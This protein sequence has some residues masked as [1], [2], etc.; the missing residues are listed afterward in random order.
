MATTT[1]KT[2]KLDKAT[3]ANGL[4]SA[5][6][7]ALQAAAT[8]EKPLAV[9]AENQLVALTAT[10]EPLMAQELVEMVTSTNQAVQLQYMA[11]LAGIIAAKAGELGLDAGYQQASIIQNVLTTFLTD[12][13]TL[14]KNP[15]VQLLL[16]AAVVAAGVAI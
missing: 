2:L 1:P 6:Q 15:N 7:N 5:L 4:T 3:L 12:V 14:V 8:A 13:A 10:L 11:G 9:A 16:K